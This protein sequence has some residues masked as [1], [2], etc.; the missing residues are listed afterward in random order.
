M[1]VSNE[2]WQSV[3]TDL[4]ERS[5]LVILQVG[6]TRGL[7]W[8]LDRVDELKQ[9]GEVILFTPFGLFRNTK[10]KESAYSAFHEWAPT[11]IPGE[12]P[13][14]IGKASFLYFEPGT[15]WTAKTL[16]YKGVVD[17]AHP[18]SELLRK[19]ARDRAF[20]PEPLIGLLGWLIIVPLLL[21]ILALVAVLLLMFFNR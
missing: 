19:L 11:C 3:A 1:Y 15:G 2:D 16:T 6:E 14:E 12:F 4:M 21:M 5:Q 9:P 17:A 10:R 7:Q 20:R 13:A 18:R 8:E